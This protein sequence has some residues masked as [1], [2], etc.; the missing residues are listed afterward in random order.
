MPYYFIQEVFF[1][2]MKTLKKCMAEVGLL[3]R[4]QLMETEECYRGKPTIDRLILIVN[5]AR[6]VLGARH[7][8]IKLLPK[9]KEYELAIS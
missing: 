2:V 5:R 1:K 7:E 9:I 6:K 4:Y 8:L 3:Q